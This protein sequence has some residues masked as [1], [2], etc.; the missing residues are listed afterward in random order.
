MS[1]PHKK[2]FSHLKLVLSKPKLIIRLLLPSPI[3]RYNGETTENIGAY[4]KNICESTFYKTFIKTNIKRKIRLKITSTS[5][6]HAKVQI[7]IL[8][9]GT[10]FEGL[11]FGRKK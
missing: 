5:K 6:Q 2:H 9:R 1:A 11:N 4:C 3:Q 10:I 7:V 8:G